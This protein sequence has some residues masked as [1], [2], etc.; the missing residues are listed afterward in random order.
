M[1]SIGSNDID[2]YILACPP[3]TQPYLEQIRAII[4]KAAPGAAEVISY[5]MPAYKLN[6]ILVYFAG[7]K[8]HIGFYPTGSGIQA[9]Q[10]ELAG[11]KFTKGSIH[12]S[13]NQPL[14]VDLITRIVEFRVAETKQKAKSKS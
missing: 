9:F 7:C 13:Y 10:K 12:F 14:P 3:E 8:N 6:G 1:K 2:A 11:Y 4:R 5:Q